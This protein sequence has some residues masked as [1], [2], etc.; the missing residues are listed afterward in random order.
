MKCPKC[1]ST[2][3]RCYNGLNKPF[4]CICKD[5]ELIFGSE[6]V[7]NGASESD[8]NEVFINERNTK[9]EKKE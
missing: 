6:E 5:C 8:E 1:G 7:S 4:D 3:I 2:K 9:K